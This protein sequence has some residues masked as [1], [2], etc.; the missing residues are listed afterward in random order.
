MLGLGTLGIGFGRMGSGAGSGVDPLAPGKPSLDL[1]DDTGASSTDNITNEVEPEFEVVFAEPPLESDHVKF[2]KNGVEVADVALTANQANGVDP[3][4]PGLDPFD[5]GTDSLQVEHI[6]DGHTRGPGPVLSVTFDTTAPA[7]SSPTGAEATNST[8]DLSVATNEANGALYWVVT[9]SNTSPSAAQVKAGQDHLG[10][11]ALAS[12][13]QSISSTGTKTATATDLTTGGTRYAHFMHE[14]APGNQSS[15][16]TSAGWTQTGTAAPATVA[17]QT[18]R[19]AG[20]LTA[21]STADTD[22]YQ[23]TTVP[24]GSAADNRH[25]V[26]GIRARSAV[27]RTISS[28]TLTGEDTTPRSATQLLVSGDANSKTEFWIVAAPSAA[29]T[30]ATIDVDFS[31]AMLDCVIAVWR[32]DNLLSTTPVDTL[33]TTGGDPNTGTIDVTADGVLI[34]LNVVSAPRLY[35]WSAAM[36]G[37]EDFDESY[38]AGSF[39]ATGASKTISV[40]ETATV[41]VDANVVESGHRLIAVSLR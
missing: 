10:A 34:A 37:E 22:P 17:Y 1:I 7:L 9:A 4:E 38:D 21:I 23:F 19:G 11:A 39:T 35:T 18:S 12:G 26:I 30:T 32:V 20:T 27:A 25:I 29:G 15:V 28:V 33:T 14:D 6:R 41:T 13:N 16:S 24:I 3:I 8:A 36:S 40:T 5:E 31:G 2:Y